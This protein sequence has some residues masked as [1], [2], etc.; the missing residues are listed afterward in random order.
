MLVAAGLVHMEALEMLSQQ[1]H[2]RISSQLRRLTAQR[3]AAA[4][5]I[6]ALCTLTDDSAEDN[7]DPDDF[8]V[9]QVEL[10]LTN[11][12]EQVD[13]RLPYRRLIDVSTSENRTRGSDF[14]SCLTKRVKETKMLTYLPSSS[15]AGT[16]GTAK[17]THS[18]NFINLDIF[19]ILLIVFSFTFKLKFKT[20]Y[21]DHNNIDDEYF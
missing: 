10:C 1:C 6:A 19:V 15:L 7:S 9:N 11:A 14:Y 21:N 4:A 13:L 5:D 2:N 18:R 16:A 20:R 3:R 8:D 12:M 17:L